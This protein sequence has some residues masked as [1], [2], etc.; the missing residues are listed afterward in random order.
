M[1]EECIDEEEVGEAVCRNSIGADIE[2]SA[3]EE[4]LK[5]KHQQETPSNQMSFGSSIHVAGE[6]VGGLKKAE[7]EGPV[8]GQDRTQD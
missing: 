4:E 2:V 3:E 5:K 6:S 1:H 8:G 7:D